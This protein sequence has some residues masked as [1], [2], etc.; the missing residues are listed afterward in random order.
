MAPETPS[1]RCGGEFEASHNGE[2]GDQ[3]RQPSSH[4]SHDR[5]GDRS[6]A[7]SLSPS[8]NGTAARK[9]S[10]SEARAGEATT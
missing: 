6:C 8:V 4:S 2:S 1:R 9:S 3:R 7:S 10:C 5:L